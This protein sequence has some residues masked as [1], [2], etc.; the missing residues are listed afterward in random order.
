M[1]VV[2][3]LGQYLLAL[4]TLNLKCGAAAAAAEDPAAVCKDSRV[5]MEHMV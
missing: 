4:H 1:V 5:A 2:A 3:V